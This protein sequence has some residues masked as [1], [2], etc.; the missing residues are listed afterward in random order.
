MAEY[1]FKVSGM[2]CSGCASRVE[3]ALKAKP[4]V[5]TADVNF[6]SESATVTG[7]MERSDLYEWIQ[8]MGYEAFDM[9]EPSRFN[10]D[11]GRLLLMW[12]M[13]LPL[14]ALAM[15]W[16]G[17]DLPWSPWIQFALNTGVLMIGGK[18]FI[19]RAWRLL[20][21]KDSNMDTLVALGSLAAYGLSIFQMLNGSSDLYFESS[22]M[23]I[24]LISLGKF[25][26]ERAKK[27]ANKA[28]ETLAMMS[29]NE[30]RRFES[31]QS[32][33][34]LS[35]LQVVES[36][37]LAPGD[38]LFVQ[39]GERIPADGVI[40]EGHA[41]IDASLMTGESEP[42]D[43]APGASLIGGTLNLRGSIAL[44]VEAT[45]QETVLSQMIRLVERAMGGKPPIQKLA[46][47]ISQVFV[48]VVVL[49]SFLSLV[50]GLMLGKET[51]DAVLAA[52]SV[53]VIS[54]PCALGL[55][56]PVA[57]VS[58][59]GYA[60][61]K[62]LLIRDLS[63][64]ESLS[65]CQTIVFDKTGTL[66]EGA[67]KLGRVVP[68]SGSTPWDESQLKQMCVLLERHSSHPLAKALIESLHIE[69]RGSFTVSEVEEI[70]GFGLKG[71]LVEKGNRYQLSLGRVEAEEL[72]EDLSELLSESAEATPMLLKIDDRAA[73]LLLFSDSLRSE[74]HPL[75]RSLQESGLEIVI[76]SGDRTQV[77][78][79]VAQSL[80]GD[81]K[82]FGALKPAEKVE[83]VSSFR[84][85]GKHVAMVGDG[86]NDG[87]ALAMADVGL[88]M[89][90]G[91]DL[92]FETAGIVLRH[93]TVNS[94]A[95]AYYLSKRTFKIIKQN[96]VWAFLYNT[97]LI[98]VAALGQLTPMMAAGAMTA[99]SLCVVLNG[100]R[101]SR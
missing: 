91:S 6:A 12:G 66:T 35:S 74:A 37:S 23:I 72:S 52:I 4:L 19:V 34:D 2:T 9:S 50:I 47:K 78:H 41:S 77:V 18:P 46:D 57:L 61:R 92:A 87:P 63:A 44:K 85:Q 64:L 20:L 26:E 79:H 27:S 51:V 28:I 17:S 81:V 67:P 13:T 68:L 38:I 56:T 32:L 83:L 55:A 96:L 59:S 53:L 73:L 3:K 75:I 16:V 15:G 14:M 70:P 29:P 58:A 98:P 24:A 7:S 43:C 5:S 93:G 88:A 36:K 69:E 100:L 21:T 62:G 48:P 90:N 45:G 82:D 8:A 39:T 11:R 49:I 30:A 95:D 101:L 54:C 84:D 42:L 33:T 97:I 65:Q 94:V 10:F 89:G 22:A 76:A 80:P 40:L 86:V 99:S 71:Q 31:Y 60:A 25:I 1:R